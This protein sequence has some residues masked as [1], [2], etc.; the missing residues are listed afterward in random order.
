[1]SA[2]SF[3]NSTSVSIEWNMKSFLGSA[4]KGIRHDLLLA[5]FA[6]IAVFA[7]VPIITY[8]Y[9]VSD[10]TSENR[11]ITSND[12]GVT[13][14]DRNNNPFFTFY[15]AKSRKEVQLSDIPLNT[16]QAVL[17]MEDKDFYSHSGFSFKST[18]RAF[19]DDLQHRDLAYGGSTVTQQLV[20][21]SLLTPKK[22]I[23]RKY[24]EVVLAQEI[25]KR[26]SKQKILEMYLNSVYFGDGAFGIEQAAQT[27]FNKST[28]DLDLAESAMLAGLLPAPSRLSPFAGNLEE[29]KKH[30]KLVLDKMV[31]Q[32]YISSDQAN[33]AASEKLSLAE[34]K[35]DMNTLAPHFALMVK[36]ALIQKYGEEALAR[37]GFKVQTTIDLEWQQYAQQVVEEQVEKLRPNRVSNGA[38]VAMDPINGEVRALVGSRDWYNDSFGKVNVAISPRQTGSAFKPIVYTLGFEKKIITPATTLQDAPTAFPNF[39]DSFYSDF[40]TRQAAERVLAA[41]PNAYYKPL[42]YDRKFRGT[43]TVRRSLANSLNVP[44]VAV[45][46]KVGVD[47]VVNFAKGAGITTLKEPSNYGLALVLGTA[48]IKLLELTN[49]YATLANHGMMNNPT[50][51]LQIKD[52]QGGIVYQY[53]PDPQKIVSPQSAFL[54][55][56]ILS[57]NKT[58]SEIFGTTLNIS[59]PAA[60]K[61]GTTENYKD[62]WT[63]GF[64]PSLVVGV[65]VGNNDGAQMDNIAGS[66]GAAPIWRLLMEK[67]LA[68]T[69]VANFNPPDGVVKSSPCGISSSSKEATSSA[70]EYFIEGTESKKACPTPS[71]TPLPTPTPSPSSTPTSTLTST[72]TPTPTPTIQTQDN[73]DNRGDNGQDRRS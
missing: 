45:M 8:A 33:E 60:V 25:E 70:S 66:L 20:K 31:E 57:D 35:D 22:D 19:F 36:D 23:L 43:V 32:K 44:S 52:K 38:T 6:I 37:S 14:L 17:A 27:Y 53:Q 21:N 10:L 5:F 2:A 50:L 13:L 39:D 28:K 49:F 30:Q 54:T 15:S 71:P 63:I 29:T 61:T 47:D 18:I 16:Q 69:P 46:K 12:S 68:G 26:F 11:I 56:S 4:L 24:Q 73:Q 41:D 59:R 1:M 67:F 7:A 58:R 3:K 9:F 42:N 72:S 51:I 40:P 55:S 65:W 34:Q 48:D 64:T 62:A